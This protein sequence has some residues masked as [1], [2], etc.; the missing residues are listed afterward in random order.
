M[1]AYLYSGLGKK[2]TYLTCTKHESAQSAQAK[3]TLMSSRC[4][5]TPCQDCLS[6]LAYAPASTTFSAKQATVTWA[7][8]KQS[9][10]FGVYVILNDVHSG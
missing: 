2:Y 9:Y 10:I 5:L 7:S 3:A 6:N 8:Q 1:Y 4:M